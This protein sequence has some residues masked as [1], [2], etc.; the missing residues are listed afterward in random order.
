MSI[1]D[2]LITDRKGGFY[3]VTD[4]NRVGEAMLFVAAE[5]TAAGYH[6][7]ITPKTDW[8]YHDKP[9]PANMTQY[10]RCLDTL[11]RQ[12]VMLRTS[13]STPPTMEKL[14]PQRA[15]DIEKILVDI[16]DLIGRVRGSYF[17]SGEPFA[18]EV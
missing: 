9:T 10:L 7:P 4:L 3:N 2:T 5:L 14:T 6:T 17:Y 16:D 13:P 11:R 1:I 18:G 12:L 15:N 8:S